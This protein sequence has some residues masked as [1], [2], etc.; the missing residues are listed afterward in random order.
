MLPEIIWS[1]PRFGTMNL[2]G[3]LLPAYRG[4]APIQWAIIKG[5]KKTGLTTFLL[6]HEIDKGDVLYQREIPILDEDNAGSLHDRM[7]E[8]GAGLVLGSVDQIQ[9]GELKLISQDESRASHAPKIH[10]EDGHIDWY[11]SVTEI[12]NLIRGMS[13]YPGAWTL[14]D[15]IECKI[16]KASPHSH[17]NARPIGSLNLDN[18]KLIVQAE[19]GELEILEIQM[20][21]KKKML[22]RDF[23]NGYK[24]KNWYTS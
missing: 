8:A 17:L 9:T 20:A 19:G 1:M 4:A 11:K 7:M 14:I 3:S 10:H 15:N 18:N 6:Q 12:K 5:E 22:V 13:P 21:G 23:L 16:L 2:H 24:I